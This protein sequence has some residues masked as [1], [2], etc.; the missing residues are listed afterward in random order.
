M[1]NLVDSV[2]VTIPSDSTDYNFFICLS[3]LGLDDLAH[4]KFLGMRF[5]KSKEVFINHLSEKLSIEICKHL[6]AI[7]KEQD[8]KR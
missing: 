8:D 5:K 7:D 2:S 4:Y 1:Y 6:L 3:S